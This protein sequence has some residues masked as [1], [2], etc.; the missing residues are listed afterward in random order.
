[1][2][3]NGRNRSALPLWIALPSLAVFAAGVSTAAD[4][5]PYVR[6]KDMPHLQIDKPHSDQFRS[7]TV[8]IQLAPAEEPGWRTEYKVTV[9]AGDALVYSLTSTGP[10]ISEFH[11][12]MLPSGS[13]MFYR[14]EKA[15]TASHGQFL[16]PADGQH[17]WY[18]ANTTNKPVKVT[19]KLSGYYTVDPGFIEFND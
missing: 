15:T 6:T 17:G 13:V 8:E 16:S 9:N 3:T 7:D 1:M 2:S 14:E 11:N 12:E 4:E 18:V 19:L 10:V 5:R